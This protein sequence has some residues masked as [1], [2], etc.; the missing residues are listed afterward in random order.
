VRASAVGAAAAIA[1]ALAG[2]GGHASTQ[3]PALASYV[4]QVNHVE[5]Q[6]AKPF[7]AVTN[8][9]STFAKTNGTGAG[10]LSPKVQEQ[11]LLR[12]MHRIRTL[13]L[14]LAQIPAPGPALHLRKLLLRLVSGEQSM[15][16]QLS[17]LVAFL[18]QFS[19]ILT[20]L[21]PATTK[22][23]NALKVTTP[24]GFGTAGVQAELAVKAKA[25]H[26]YEEVLYQTIVRLRKLDPPALSR[27]QLVT[28]VKTLERMQS[29]AG[30]LA[31][32]LVSGSS[33]IRPL[34]QAFD[35]A[36]AGTR[37]VAAQRAQIAAIKAYD[38][39]AAKL[40]Q[41]AKAVELERTRLDRNLK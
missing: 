8:A 32:A 20:S 22:L 13:R 33:N 7:Q 12:A 28:Q 6:L 21:A 18:P 4:D 14:H 16:V 23:Q 10:H 1:V 27:P 19:K 3:R 30:K 41:L 38:A 11:K 24:L 37:S 25:L 34:L 15:T 31:D 26:A 2:C 35:R 40:D 17:K 5:K 39:R 29:T 36:A 9:G